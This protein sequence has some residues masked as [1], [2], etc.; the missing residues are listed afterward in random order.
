MRKFHVR[1]LTSASRKKFHH[2]FDGSK[3]DYS[4]V[5]SLAY[6]W[7]CALKL[8]RVGVSTG[9]FEAHIQGVL[10]ANAHNDLIEKLK[11]ISEMREFVE[12]TKALY[13]KNVKNLY[14][15]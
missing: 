11:N 8:E 4:Y 1:Y 15:N 3:G 14:A 13:D 12:F 6:E 2:I 5:L 7:D 9:L 10:Y